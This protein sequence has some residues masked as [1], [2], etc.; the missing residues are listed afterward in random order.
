VPGRGQR[1][2]REPDK[3][4]LVCRVPADTTVEVGEIDRRKVSQ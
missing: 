1:G 4:L 2:K 3:R